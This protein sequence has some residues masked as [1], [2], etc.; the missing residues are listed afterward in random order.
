MAKRNRETLKNH[1][2][3][4]E[5][6]TQQAFEDLIDSTLNTLDDGFSGSPHIGIGLS[7]LT[8]KGVII[9]TFRSPGD[10][11]PAWEIVINK[12]SGDFE[13][14]RCEN[15]ISQPV[16]SIKHQKDTQDQDSDII[17]NGMIRCKGIKGSYKTG[18]VRADGKWHD[19]LDESQ[20]EEGCVA[21][22][23]T[24]GCGERNKGRYA[25]LTA[26][27]MHC[28]G[29]RCK[30]KK[31]RSNFGL[32]GNRLCLRWVKI[33]NK[34]ACRLQIKTS[35]RYGEGVMIRYQI[36]QLWDNPMSE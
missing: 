2:K 28:Y 27:A 21:L 10:Q 16:F 36:S 1:F 17:L 3:Q 35:F 9:S 20:Q 12:N 24:A 19:L 14:Q 23:V 22:E 6:P 15:G 33:K 29:S 4:G 5:R 8:E 13:I 11:Y 18:Q 26:T 34:F 31:V 30:I 25:L 7:P 32:W